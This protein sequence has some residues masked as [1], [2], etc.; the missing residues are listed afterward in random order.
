MPRIETLRV[1]HLCHFLLTRVTLHFPFMAVHEYVRRTSPDFI[2]SLAGSEDGADEESDTKFKFAEYRTSSEISSKIRQGLWHQG[3]L[4]MNR[5]NYR[6]GYVPAET[7][8]EDILISGIE[9]LNRALNGDVVVVELLP[10]EEWTR[11]SRLFHEE[12]EEVETEGDPLPRQPEDLPK[13]PTG[14]VVG[15]IKR[16]WKP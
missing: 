3:P 13:K 8:D 11:P 4:R 6:E 1:L 12:E 2:D 14:K 5:D 10:K 15:V 7:L 9:H 16:N